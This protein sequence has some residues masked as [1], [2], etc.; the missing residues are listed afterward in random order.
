M[1][2]V[3]ARPLAL[4][5]PRHLADVTGSVFDVSIKG[6]LTM[7]DGRVV[8][9][10]NERNE[11]ELPGGRIEPGETPA[12]C[13][14]REI[15]EELGLQVEV[16]ARPID[17]YLFEVTPGRHVFIATYPCALAGP[18]DPKVSHEHKRFGLFFE[19]RLPENLPSGYRESITSVFRRADCSLDRA[20]SGATLQTHFRKA[21]PYPQPCCD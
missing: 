12:Q 10:E 15:Q 3:A 1:T 19:D 16:G 11:W 6:V 17:T 21:S 4:D 5:F 20:T 13:L 9:L 18:F 2:A 8:L 7:P 14:A